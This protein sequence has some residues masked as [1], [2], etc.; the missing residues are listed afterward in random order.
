MRRALAAFSLLTAIAAAT[1][2]VQAC[3]IIVQVYPPPPLQVERLSPEWTTVLAGEVV[4]ARLVRTFEPWG[5]TGG[6][7]WSVEI[8]PRP[9]AAVMPQPKTVEWIIDPCGTPMRDPVVGQE[10]NL[11]LQQENRTWTV[12]DT[13]SAR[14][15]RRYVRWRSS[16]SEAEQAPPK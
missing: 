15:L 10:V 13:I 16:L 3:E 6:R 2:P 5:M 4:S 9:L 11:L 14:D 1:A 7:V 12:R 8:A